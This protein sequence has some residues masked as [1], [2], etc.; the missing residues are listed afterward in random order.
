MDHSCGAQLW[1][2]IVEHI[3]EAQL[4]STVARLFV[5]QNF[6]SQLRGWKMSQLHNRLL[7]T[8]TRC[9]ARWLFH[10]VIFLHSGF[11]AHN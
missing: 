7:Y 11:V 10:K 2:T 8:C 9:V 6:L 3:C 5:A 1:S 4:W